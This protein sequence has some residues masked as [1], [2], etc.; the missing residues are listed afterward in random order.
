MPQPLL[1]EKIKQIRKEAMFSILILVLSLFFV[2]TWIGCISIN[3]P[4]M[5]A[6]PSMA[7]DAYDE[8]GRFAQVPEAETPVFVSII[9]VVITVLFCVVIGAALSYQKKTSGSKIV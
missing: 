7:R 2:F 4:S 3:V 9:G 8:L 1:D 5:L 6:V